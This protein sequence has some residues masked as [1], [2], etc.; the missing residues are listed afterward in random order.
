[1]DSA[2]TAVAPWISRSEKPMLTVSQIKELLKLQ[3]L[4]LEGGFFAEVYR[5]A[6]QAV[7]ERVAARL[8]RGSEAYQPQS[9]IC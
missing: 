7:L 4:P 8:F 9:I 3:P 1:M 6:E 5:S 2:A